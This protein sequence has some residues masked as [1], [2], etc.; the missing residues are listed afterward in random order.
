M[1]GFEKLSTADEII[2]WSGRLIVV[3]AYYGSLE[4]SAP[5]ISRSRREQWQLKRGPDGKDPRGTL[6][7]DPGTEECL[8][9]ASLPT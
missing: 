3:S 5:G 6:I 2:V 8:A 1:E 9:P 7:L 4:G